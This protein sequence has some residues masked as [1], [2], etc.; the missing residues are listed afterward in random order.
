MMLRAFSAIAFA[1]ALLCIACTN[2]DD[3]LYDESEATFIEVSAEMAYSFDS[4]SERNKC[5]TLHPG[6]SLIFIANILPSK[7]IKIKRY[8]WTIDGNPFSYDFSFRSAIWEPGLHK[9]VFIL[10][11]FFGD[12]LSDTLT[13][14]ISNS[15]ALQDSLFI[16]AKGTQGIPTTGGLSFAWK[17]YD[18]DSIAS[19]YYRFTIDG[20]VDTI[21][22]VPYFTYW[23]AFKPLSHY[24]WH[25]QAI[26]E[27]GFISE[28]TIDGDFFTNGSPSE[29]GI[30]GFFDV[31]A[32]DIASPFAY[33][34]KLS[35]LDTANNEVYND[36]IKGSSQS[37]RPFAISPLNEGV[38]KAVFSIPKYPDFTSDTINFSLLANEVLDLDTIRLRDTI[39]PTIAFIEDGVVDMEKDT[40]KYADTLRF[41]ITD[42]G[43]P[44]SK[45]TISA[46]LESVLLTEKSNEGDTF[47]VVLP[48]N[49]KTWNNRLLDIVAIDASKNRTTRN[50]TLEPAESWIK[51]NNSFTQEGPGKIDLYVIDNNPYG[52]PL[53]TCK[54]LVNGT[55]Y[56]PESPNPIL[57]SVRITTDALEPGLNTIE[58]IAV[59]D[60]GINQVK[61]WY[62]TYNKE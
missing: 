20:L 8:I 11:T 1:M 57:C 41:L 16:P 40:L 43:T 21:L 13:L 5:D 29:S 7:S 23:G 39:A 32:R 54:F 26:N 46:Y 53:Y 14:R 37:A 15:P 31:S 56:Q 12:T 17:G 24:R 55:L 9:V 34:M 52:F 4:I 3:F 47:T 42:F 6:D 22:S 61:T 60:N 10:E 45:K 30:T 19:L 38:Y 35:I 25:V 44:Q 58:S 28:N 2:S 33:T 62:I 48:T 27:F 59:Y 51:T 50:Y 18:P 36:S 49:T